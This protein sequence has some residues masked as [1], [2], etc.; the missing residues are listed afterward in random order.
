MQTNSIYSF[1][2]LIQKS[3]KLFSGDES[4]E[5][6]IK[7]GRCY[8]IIIAEDA[9]ENTKSKF[10]NLSNENNI[11]FIIFGNKQILGERIGKL[12]RAV[13]AINDLNFAK[14]LI[15]KIQNNNGGDHS[16]KN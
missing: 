13:L 15:K 5:N 9:S 8:L 6:S 12:N 14:G 7:K 4:V 16:A 2:S 11:P 3:G 1:I 10:I